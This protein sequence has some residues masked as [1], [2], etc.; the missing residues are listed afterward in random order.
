VSPGAKEVT[1]KWATTSEVDNAGFNVYRAELKN[2]EYLKINPA[3]IP[4]QGSPTQGASYEY[5]DKNAKNGRACFYKLED[6][7]I[8]GTSTMHGPVNV[9]ASK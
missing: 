7:D 3:L 4:A 5:I 6:I 2:G 9:T 8:H 1:L